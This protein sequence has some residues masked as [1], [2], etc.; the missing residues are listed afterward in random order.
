MARNAKELAEGWYDPD[1]KQK[2][3]E[4][5]DRSAQEIVE[6][7]EAHPAPIKAAR[8]AADSNA[9]SDDDDDDYGPILPP[10]TS[11]RSNR[12]GPAAPD[13]S[14]L[15]LR[16]EQAQADFE[17]ARADLRHERKLDRREQKERLDEL[18][19]RA[20]GGTRERQLEKKRDV[21]MA[22]REFAAARGGGDGV[23]E[24]AENELM[25]GGGGVDEVRRMRKE[26]ERKKNEREIRREEILRAR[27]AERE[28]RMAVV[29]K[30]EEKTMEMLQVSFGRAKCCGDECSC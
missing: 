24:V 7:E 19:P 16:R 29:R 15:T 6:E 21:A 22:N 12:A 20:E 27:A 14:D 28:E 10:G 25:G 30:R 17:D 18:V 13:F 3:D 1:T 4:S 9:A 26:E 8:A 2:A 11:S 23:A 5:A